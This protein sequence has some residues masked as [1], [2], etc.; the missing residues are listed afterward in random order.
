[1]EEGGETHFS[2]SHAKWARREPTAARR[3]LRG[4]EGVGV[5]FLHLHSSFSRPGLEGGAHRFA[6]PARSRRCRA[7]SV[8]I[9]SPALLE[10]FVSG[11]GCM[12]RR[13]RGG[14]RGLVWPGPG[15]RGGRGRRPDKFPG[16]RCERR[17]SRENELGGPWSPRYLSHV[18]G[19]GVRGRALRTRTMSSPLTPATSS[20]R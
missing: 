17:G 16:H 8:G 4:K 9:F 15:G 7:Q 19:Q 18:A 10:W 6:L 11:E 1:M 3:R 13:S 2:H 5:T 14:G 12:G 20:S